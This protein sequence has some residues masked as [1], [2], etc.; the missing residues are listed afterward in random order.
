MACGS[1]LT[2]DG[3][4][5]IRIAKKRKGIDQPCFDGRWKGAEPI[6]EGKEGQGEEK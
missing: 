1:E 4:A 6:C 5:L 3:E 2:G